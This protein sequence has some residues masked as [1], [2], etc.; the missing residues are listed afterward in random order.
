MKKYLFI[1][2]GLGSG[3]STE[4]LL[5]YLSRLS[6]TNCKIHIITPYIKSQKMFYKFKDLGISI[7]LIDAGQFHSSQASVTPIYKV[8]FELIKYFLN[9]K[10][11]INYIE[12]N[13]IDL[14]HLN[15]T[16]I[17][18]LIKLIKKKF[19]IP[20]FIFV[21]EIIQI[22]LDDFFIGRF[23]KKNIEKWASGIICISENESKIFLNSKK[24]RVLYNPCDVKNSEE[25]IENKF[26]NILMVGQFSLSK[27]HAIFLKSVRYF[28]DHYPNKAKN[29]KFKILGIPKKRN[30]SIVNFLFK[31]NRDILNFY[32]IFENLELQDIVQIEDYIEDP[33][34]YFARSDIL[35]RPSLSSDPWGR[36]IIEAMS[37]STAIIATGKYNKFVKN[38]FNG[39]LVKA[40]QPILISKALE[41]IIPDNIKTFSRNSKDL[42]TR[43][44]NPDRY[45]EIMLEIYQTKN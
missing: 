37:L 34:K 10:K 39:F 38:N 29:C 4:S 18:H 14:V 40:N 31:K 35:V 23:H 13:S 26:I 8:P 16:V 15:S 44:F 11:I 19:R 6:K 9:K 28:I 24:V 27:G 33:E 25:I 43:L 45:L 21:R 1:L 36:D 30:N 3:G 2:S 22:N 5:V 17:S 7:K 20:V 41:N 42:A 32:K 12:E